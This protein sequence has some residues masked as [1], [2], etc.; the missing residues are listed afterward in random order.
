M[1]VGPQLFPSLVLWEEKKMHKWQRLRTNGESLRSCGVWQKEHRNHGVP[2]RGWW[3]R[4]TE[5]RPVEWKGEEPL[6]LCFQ[7]EARES[8]LKEFGAASQKSKPRLI[9]TS[10]AEF[11]LLL[12]AVP[13]ASENIS[14]FQ[15]LGTH[16]I[17]LST[18]GFF[19]FLLCLY[20]HLIL[21]RGKIPDVLSSNSP[22]QISPPRNCQT[23]IR[24]H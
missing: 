18:C 11:P 5:S 2:A 8:I 20:F 14:Q 15:L 22:Q 23:F 1:F 17:I 3:N 7:L 9:K 16:L 24:Q 21:R 19:S 4:A 10:A 13:N 12:S 6:L